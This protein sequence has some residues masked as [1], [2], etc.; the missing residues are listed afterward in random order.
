MKA[1]PSSTFCKQT[2]A[3]IHLE[4]EPNDKHGGCNN[5]VEPQIR[6]EVIRKIVNTS[7]VFC[8]AV[9]SGYLS[10]GSSSLRD[11][12]YDPHAHSGS[13]HFLSVGV[14][15]VRGHVISGVARRRTVP[16][17]TL[18]WP[19]HAA[20]CFLPLLCLSLPASKLK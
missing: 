19:V 9:Q 3:C 5:F 2:P 15:E 18:T 14:A 13:K 11:L 6:T 20:R 16:G 10:A 17:S 12:L 4:P 1:V 8:L 7:G